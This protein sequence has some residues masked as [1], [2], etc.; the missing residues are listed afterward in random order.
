MVVLGLGGLALACVSDP[1]RVTSLHVSVSWTALATDQLQF[2]VIPE[3]GSGRALVDPQM[4]P[5]LP[6][7][8]M[9]SPQD[10]F[11][12][13]RD[14]LDGTAVRCRVS[15]L[16]KGELRQLGD[17]DVAT[18]RRGQPVSCDVIL[19]PEAP[20]GHLPNGT[21]C[22]D[23][24][25][26]DSAFCVDGL[27]CDGRCEGSCMACD[28]TSS[29]GICSFVPDGVPPRD[30]AQCRDK[31]AATCDADGTCDGHGDCRRYPAGTLCAAGLCDGSAV[32]GGRVCD[33]DGLCVPGPAR[34]CAPF[35]CDAKSAP[36]RCID[37]CAGDADCADGH[38]C[39]E[40]SCG[41]RD[42]G[43][44]CT[45][46]AQ[47]RSG[48]CVDGLCCNEVCAGS[49]V[50][51]NQAG[52]EGSCRSVATGKADPRGICKDNRGADPYACGQ[53]GTCDGKGG[54]AL[55]AT[56]TLCKAPTCAGTVMTRPSTCDGAGTCQPGTTVKC[57]PFGCQDGH[58]N[59]SCAAGAD[60]AA[61]QSCNTA[62]MSCGLKGLGQTCG[63][64][65][66]CAGGICADGV[67]CNEACGGACRSCA[68]P[69]SAGVCGPV[70]VGA[71][72]PRG[73]CKATPAS[74]CG[75]DGMCDGNGACRRH[76]PGTICAAQACT[77]SSLVPVSRCDGTGTC[78][79]ETAQACA[80]FRC[81]GGA[82]CFTACSTDADC[83]APSTCQ[84]GAC[85]LRTPGATCKTDAECGGGHCTDGVC[86]AAAACA[87]C[88]ACNVP[89]AA[90]QCA[91]ISALTP[92]PHGACVNQGPDSCGTDGVCNGAG[93][94]HIYAPGTACGAAK[95]A[96]AVLTPAPV[97][98]GLG[99]CVASGTQGGCGLKTTGSPCAAAGECDSGSCVDG[100]CCAAAMCGTCQACNVPGSAGH[101][102]PVPV[103]TVDV[104]CKGTVA[105]GC[106]LDG[107]CDGAGV[108]RNWPA[109]TVCEAA[110]CMGMKDSHNARTCD[111]AGSCA[112]R[113]KI[114]CG[115][116]GC[117][118]VTGLCL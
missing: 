108:C 1:A 10:V 6:A 80:P 77:G 107:T 60:C 27:C 3:T 103:A 67:C 65:A 95:C 55:Y 8:L 62:T 20:P 13:L 47:C 42:N 11:I 99:T 106:K 40:G 73:T 52:G 90:G 81:N 102:A 25:Q 76:V 24:R 93:A 28:L 118:P 100:V 114:M 101:C 5:L 58:C 116:V 46:E 72:D 66:E 2:S 61:G 111:G 59:A 105:R 92:E 68:L 37:V 97:C 33:G 91:N 64:G 7:D 86:C 44:V 16:L 39:Q 84:S 12:R 51:C 17:S 38:T 57:E 78:V 31:G 83:V 87:I 41:A 115:L 43:G 32:V 15:A 75:A 69:G 94:C 18:V 48:H 88:Q 21:P 56:N 53:T 50:S 4:R 36:A 79:P 63:A 96:G 22:A 109:G 85:K 49:C 45:K 110:T 29:P 117:D 54:C 26:C 9:T 23:N 70:A 74:T 89:G 113:G 34:I 82:S 98:D 35:L 104:R 19:P 112:D 14:E 71:V 30:L